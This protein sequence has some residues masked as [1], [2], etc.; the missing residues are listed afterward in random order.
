MKAIDA[1][2]ALIADRT[3]GL[4]VSGPREL[5]ALANGQSLPRTCIVQAVPGPPLYDEPSRLVTYTVRCYG[6]TDDE[7][8]GTYD[9]LLAGLH[10]AHGDPLHGIAVRGTWWLLAAALGTPGSPGPDPEGG[11]FPVVLATVRLHWATQELTV[12]QP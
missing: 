9:A 2:V 5:T 12:T 6:D 4:V 7:A 11:K 8:L 10:D 1:A 3:T